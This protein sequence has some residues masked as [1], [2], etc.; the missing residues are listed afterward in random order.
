LTTTEV[1][2]KR[3]ASSEE[4]LPAA[5]RALAFA[6]AAID[7]PTR[8]QVRDARKLVMRVLAAMDRTLL[9]GEGAELV[10]ALER[11]AA[12]LTGLEAATA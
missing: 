1:V 7:R 9:G 2:M 4:L 5:R 8:S 3:K 6:Y 11:V 12:A 10:A